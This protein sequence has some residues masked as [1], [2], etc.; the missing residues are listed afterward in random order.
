[1]RRFLAAEDPELLAGTS[2]HGLACGCSGCL[3][4]PLP[5]EALRFDAMSDAD[6]I[7]MMSRPAK[8]GKLASGLTNLDVGV[9]QLSSDPSSPFKLYIDF[10]GDDLAGPTPVFDRDNDP[11]S[12]S[13]TEVAA[14]T[15]IWQRVVEKFSPF[16]LDVTTIDPGH[17]SNNKMVRVL[18]G[19]RGDWYGNAGGVASIGAYY[20]TGDNLGGIKPGSAKNTVYAFSARF[21]QTDDIAEV[22]AH[23]AGHAFGLQHQRNYSADGTLLG[24]YYYGANGKGPMMGVAY[25][26]D[27]ALWWDGRHYPAG[28]ARQ[29]DLAVITNT[30]NGFGYRHD[31]I[32]DSP[33]SPV[34]LTGTGDGILDIDGIIETSTD[35]DAYALDLGTGMAEFTLSVDPLDAMLDASLKVY[36]LAGGGASLIA[37]AATASLGEFL[38]V[39]I[40]QPGRYVVAVESAGDYFD[41]GQYNLYGEF[42][43]G[44]TTQVAP[45]TDLAATTDFLNGVQLLWTD[46]STTETGFRIERSIDEVNWST[47]GTVGAG[48]T[49]Y[50]DANINPV[51]TYFYRIVT[52]AAAGDAVP[53]ATARVRTPTPA[54]TAV[55][56]ATALNY[57]EVQ[58]SWP[59]Q[60]GF[61][62]LMLERRVVG[63]D[64]WQEAYTFTAQTSF[65]DRGLTPETTYEYRLVSFVYGAF[66][67]GGPVS[68]PV[69][70]DE[71]LPPVM[72][73]NVSAVATSLY[74]ATVTWSDVPNEE[75][76]LVQQS[77]D[78][79]NWTTV[80]TRNKN[81]TNAFFSGLTPE[82]TYFFR[83]VAENPAGQTASATVSLTMPA[84]SIPAKPTGLFVEEADGDYIGV[85]WD[86]PTLGNVTEWTVQMFMYDQ[87]YDDQYWQTVAVVEDP[88]VALQ[89]QLGSTEQLRVIASN[90]LGSSPPSDALI[91]NA[92]PPTPYNLVA[93]V[94]AT[95]DVVL[96]WSD[97]WAEVG[98]SVERRVVGAPGWFNVIGT[99]PQNVTTYTDTNAAPSTT[100]EYRIVANG[101]DWPSQ[102]GNVVTVTTSGM[103]S[104]PPAATFAEYDDVFLT[105]NDRYNVLVIWSDVQNEAGYKVERRIAGSTTWTP[106]ATLAE[107]G[108]TYYDDATALQGTSYEYRVAA[109][110]A[111]GDAPWAEAGQ[112]NTPPVTPITGLTAAI[113]QE[114]LIITWNP[115]FG[116][117]TRVE[118]SVAGGA[119]TEFADLLGDATEVE[120]FDIAPGT[121]YAFRAIVSNPVNTAA[122]SNVAT[123]LTVPATP[124]GLA[125]SA[126]SPTTILLSWS[127]VTGESGYQLERSADGLNNWS[128]LAT[129]AANGTSYEDVVSPEA[130]WHY[131]VR[132]ANASGASAYSAVVSATTPPD[133]PAIYAYQQVNGLV[134]FEAE[135]YDAIV[136]GSTDA[137]SLITHS[138][139]SSGEGMFSGPDNGTT[140]DGSN[141]QVNSPRLDYRVTFTSAGTHY[142]WVRGRAGGSSRGSSDTVHVGLDG[143]LLASSD[144]MSGFQTS[145][146]WRKSTMD[147]ARATIV[148]P[149]AGTYTIN[150][151][152]REDGFVADKVLLTTSS[153]YNPSGTGPAESARV[154]V[155]AAAALPESPLPESSQP[156]TRLPANPFESRRP[157]LVA[158]PSAAGLFSNRAIDVE[159][160][161]L[162]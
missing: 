31:S 1:M 20:N 10:T 94:N 8:G 98:Y 47:L 93:S 11:T 160:N 59:Q 42:T 25:S 43:P 155:P 63:S 162:A 67:D 9:P 133:Q 118:V 53:S 46:N 39:N 121:T 23:E 26:V 126:T 120:Y 84:N 137:W 136:A 16:D 154:P 109:Y 57:D 51:S 70:T 69:T 113:A 115:G 140:L 147:R 151:W 144:R 157:G 24:Q 30:N 6:A 159:E 125:A 104:Q 72:P 153:G 77:S 60:T 139:A 114:G 19:G 45:A 79:T 37:S 107:P 55:P 89:L 128:L 129:V 134:T 27:R 35:V 158:L 138:S 149:A 106:L 122:A 56:S 29:S 80:Y 148:I 2:G 111:A 99:T 90:E 116:T 22:V 156:E 12:F 123:V 100:Y 44:T 15:E 131:R 18:T 71:V 81:V 88:F 142:V 146:S 50:F 85:S 150:L 64:V 65:T 152:M 74:S 49:S 91:I 7:S 68:T 3:G 38:S 132:A 108:R 66:S 78:G 54:P 145:F 92:P 13:A 21:S 101:I 34:L 119:F 48:T 4:I 62:K 112:V 105:Y 73:T 75:R 96:T 28:V 33:A 40:T 86:Y 161:L 32:S 5:K 130:T 110:N 14:M 102:P 143:V 58:V 124:T 141:A 95:G 103:V 87:Y 61:S 76:Y 97:G 36:S 117:Q 41:I 135:H 83:V 82:A 52:T 17:R 127:D